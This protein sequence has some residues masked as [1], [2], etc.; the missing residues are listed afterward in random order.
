[1]AGLVAGSGGTRGTMTPTTASTEATNAYRY[2]EDDIAQQQNE[3]DADLPNDR[4]KKI[5]GRDKH[6]QVSKSK[7]KRRSLTHGTSMLLQIAQE[8]DNKSVQKSSK[9]DDKRRRSSESRLDTN[10]ISTKSILESMFS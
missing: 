4:K 5:R 9:N 10:G 2:K 6:T 8:V 1:M 7:G 3:N